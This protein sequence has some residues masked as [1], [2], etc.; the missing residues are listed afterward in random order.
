MNHNNS[1]SSSL[2][3]VLQG[4][5]SF[6]APP[7]Q[8]TQHQD[9]D[10]RKLLKA[11]HPELEELKNQRIAEKI[12]RRIA[13]QQSRHHRRQESNQSNQSG[14]SGSQHRMM[15][16]DFVFLQ[17]K[18]KKQIQ[19]LVNLV[20]EHYYFVVVVVVEKKRKH[21]QPSKQYFHYYKED[22]V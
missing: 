2:D 17:L 22:F 10:F 8:L 14:T 16:N 11:N 12:K 4:L 15:M 21:E 13:R 7:F 20:F 1:S 5:L 3:S 18:E 6:P 9:Y 19:L